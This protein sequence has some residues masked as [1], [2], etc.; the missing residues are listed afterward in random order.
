MNVLEAL[1]Q[2]IQNGDACK[3]METVRQALKQGYAP[4]EILKRLL[5]GINLVSEKFKKNELYI[6]HIMLAAR[7]MNAG[8]EVIRASL[9]S[10]NFNY[11]EGR[12]IIGTVKGDLHDLGKNMVKAM[13][14][15]EGFQVYDMGRDVSEEEYVQAAL[16]FKPHVLAISATMTSTVN[17][18][19]DVMQAIEKAGLRKQLIIMVGGLP[20]TDAFAKEVGADICAI[21]PGEAAELARK[22]Y[23]LKFKQA[24]YHVGG[25]GV[26][27]QA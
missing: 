24:E 21:D 8:L 6:P 25:G 5:A 1:N 4:E 12:A 2:H 19:R 20:V 15:K 7:A 17:G 11:M 26:V 14:E 16:K 22:K 27:N 18:I 23:L 3:V 13:L 10:G 9:S